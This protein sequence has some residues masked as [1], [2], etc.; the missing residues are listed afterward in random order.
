MMNHIV[1]KLGNKLHY[2]L[3]IFF[4]KALLKITTTSTAILIASLKGSAPLSSYFPPIHTR[5]WILDCHPTP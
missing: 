4:W 3:K 1:K 2:T 5:T